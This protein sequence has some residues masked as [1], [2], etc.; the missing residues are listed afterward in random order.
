MPAAD[1]RGARSAGHGGPLLVRVTLFDIY[2]GRPLTEDQKSLAYRLVFQA[3]DRTLTEDEIDA[4][5]GRRS[6]PASPAT[7]TVGI[8]T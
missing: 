8:R 7:S 6:R 5:R 1:G 3:A 4:R 2:R